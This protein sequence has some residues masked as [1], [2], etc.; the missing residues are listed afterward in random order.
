VEWRYYDGVADMMYCGVEV[1]FLCYSVDVLWSGGS[2]IVL[3]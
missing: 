2:V 1:V 3:S